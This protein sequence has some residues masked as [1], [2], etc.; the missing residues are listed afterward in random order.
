MIKKGV[1]FSMLG[2]GAG[3]VAIG[4]G[5]AAVGLFTN[6][7]SALASFHST[8]GSS[9]SLALEFFWLVS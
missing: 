2:A 1:D 9:P 4:L 6:R 5:A 3:G 7:G 8:V